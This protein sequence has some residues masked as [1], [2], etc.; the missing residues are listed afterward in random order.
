[1]SRRYE[2]W[3]I[4]DLWQTFVKNKWQKDGSVLMAVATILRLRT[5]YVKCFENAA[6]AFRLM[7]KEEQLKQIA[8]DKDWIKNFITTRQA[9]ILYLENIFDEPYSHPIH[10]G[11]DYESKGMLFKFLLIV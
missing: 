6:Q 2:E 9:N 5:P 8:Q 10:N 11:T 7:T 4:S 1:M 3:A